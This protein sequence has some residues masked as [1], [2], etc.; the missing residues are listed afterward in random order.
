MF[1]FAL[2]VNEGLEIIYQNLQSR[3]GYQNMCYFLQGVAGNSRLKCGACY[4]LALV[5]YEIVT[6]YLANKAYVRSYLV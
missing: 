6:L 5:S 3:R 4:N 1:L 2:F